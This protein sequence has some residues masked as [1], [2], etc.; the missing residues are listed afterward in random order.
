MVTHYIDK[1]IKIICLLILLSLGIFQVMT[2]NVKQPL[3][4][5]IILCYHQILATNR[6]VQHALV[7]EF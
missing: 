7:V 1:K 4:F 3:Y 2:A 5:P 6:I